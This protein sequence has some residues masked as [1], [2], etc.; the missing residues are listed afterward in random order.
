MRGSASYP[1]ADGFPRL[2]ICRGGARG[3]L[4]DR[5]GS[6]SSH[7]PSLVWMSSH[8][9]LLH[10]LLCSRSAV[11]PSPRPG[12]LRSAPLR[13]DDPWS[14]MWSRCGPKSG[15]INHSLTT[16]ADPLSQGAQLCFSSQ[17][18]ASEGATGQ[19]NGTT[20]TNSPAA[21]ARGSPP[22]SLSIAKKQDACHARR[23]LPADARLWA[24]SH[25]ASQAM[26]EQRQDPRTRTSH[27]ESSAW[28][29]SG[30][31]VGW[32]GG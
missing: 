5:L 11:S 8:T 3:L 22:R 32:R 4:V 1:W 25:R 24:R 30:D 17:P 28:D 16:L 26:P 13:L 2:F 19:G 6:G 14:G 7:L 9:S 15:A 10:V 18:R 27:I 21:A 31:R 12:M 20:N 29:A 23:P